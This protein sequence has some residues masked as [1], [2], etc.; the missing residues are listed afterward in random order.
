MKLADLI[1]LEAQLGRDRVA[2]PGALDAR[3][4]ALIARERL[5][6]GVGRSAILERWLSALRDSEPGNLHPG[7]TVAG[8][9]RAVRWGAA[10]FGLALGW[11]AATALLRYTGQEPVNVWDFLLVF[12]G[13]QILLFVL[14]LGSFFLPVPALGAP[15]AGFFRGL[16]AAVYPR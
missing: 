15:L 9:L 13:L 4:R 8:T 2:D 3:D 11:G 5:P 7:S 10:I 12:V 16:V 6:S 14:L 1:D